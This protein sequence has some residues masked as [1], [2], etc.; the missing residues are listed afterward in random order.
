MTGGMNWPPTPE[1]DSTA[2]AKW[3]LYPALFIIGMVICPT[4]ET[5][6]M[7]LPEI[8]PKRELATTAILAGPP[9]TCPKRLEARPKKKE[10]APDSCM[11]VPKRTKRKIKVLAI[12][13]SEP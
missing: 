4:A 2:A 9:R 1:A 11:K 10:P 12:P 5:L 3:G 7:A 8:I 6:A 13:V